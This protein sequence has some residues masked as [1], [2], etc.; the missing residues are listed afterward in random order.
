MWKYKRMGGSM[1]AA[2]DDSMD[3]VER[4]SECGAL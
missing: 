2:V 3:V 1:S 4:T